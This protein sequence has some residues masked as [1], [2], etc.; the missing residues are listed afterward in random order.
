MVPGASSTL[1]QYSRSMVVTVDEIYLP[2]T[3]SAPGITDEGSVLP[4]GK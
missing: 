1:V 2:L 4:E 3:L